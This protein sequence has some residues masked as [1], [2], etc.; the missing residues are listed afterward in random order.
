MTLETEQQY[1]N[2]IAELEDEIKRLKEKETKKIKNTKYG[3]NWIDVPEAFEEESK[4]AIP[5]LE[6]VKNKAIKNNDGKPTHILIEGDNFHALTCLN[7]THAGKIDV[8]YIDPPYNTG[9]EERFKYKDARF[10]KEFPNGVPVPKEHPLRHSYW[11]SF[12]SKRLKLARKLLRNNGVLFISIDENE[13]ANLHALCEEI[14]PNNV[15]VFVWRKSGMGR[16]G[17]MKNTTTFRIDHEYIIVCYKGNKKLNK[18]YELPQFQ[19][20]YGNPDDDP[21]G[22]YKAGSISNKEE[23]SNPNHEN[24]YTVVSPSGKEFTRQFNCSKKEFEELDRDKRIYWGKNNDAVPAIKIFVNEERTVTTSSII[25]DKEATTTKGSKELNNIMCDENLGKEMRPKPVA[26]IKKLSFIGGSKD[27]VVL[28]FFAGSGT[29]LQSIIELNNKDKGNR[30]CILVQINESNICEK[31]TYERNRRIITGYTDLDGKV[32][33]GLGNSLKYYKTAFIGK[34][35]A[36]TANDS[37]RI[38]LS[39]KAGSLISLSENTLEEIETTNSYQIYT[40]GERYTAIYFTEDLSDFPNFV[41]EVE[42]KKSP[43]SVFVFTWGSPDIFENE[44]TD[45]KNITI[46]A[47]PKPILEIYKSLNGGL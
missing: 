31:I 35:N 21:R 38:L 28:D 13:Q 3:L 33:P 44:F 41:E 15:E 39:Q 29:T 12:M 9:D 6:E 1:K 20:E 32:H 43:T 27:A 2:K 18:S 24:Y 23:A 30:Q 7:Y 22:P 42:N 11:L 25:D 45:L 36:T 37:D 19:N 10:L 34:N 46:K 5:I 8:I 47:I 16:D 26:L 14:F 4:N 40:N 17:K